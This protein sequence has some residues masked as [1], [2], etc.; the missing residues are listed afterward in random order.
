[1]ALRRGQDVTVNPSSDVVLAAADEII[2]LGRDQD[3]ERIGH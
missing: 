2:L 3:L 1:V